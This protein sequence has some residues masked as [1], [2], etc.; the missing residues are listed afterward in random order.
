[1]SPTC[2]CLDFAGLRRGFGQHYSRSKGLAVMR[3]P[4][5]VESTP[6][7]FGPT[8]QTIAAVV[9]YSRASASGAALAHACR[10]HSHPPPRG[11]RFDPNPGQDNRWQTRAHVRQPTCAEMRLAPQAR[12]TDGQLAGDLS[13]TLRRP[14]S[15]NTD[16][17]NL[18]LAPNNHTKITRKSSCHT[19]SIMLA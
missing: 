5:F 14:D 19:Q 7:D 8:L 12:H 13:A 6:Q 11:T 3:V 2:L 16:F 4:F 15:R 9:I 17:R 1:M 10:R 18:F